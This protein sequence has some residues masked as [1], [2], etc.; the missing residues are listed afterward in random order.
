MPLTTVVALQ[1]DALVFALVVPSDWQDRVGDHKVIGA[2][3]AS[4][5][6]LQ[7][8]VQTAERGFV[9]VAA[10]PIDQAAAIPLVGF[11]DS[12][13][14]RLAA[15]M[16]LHLIDFD[17]ADRLWRGLG[18]VPVHV[19]EDPAAHRRRGHAQE[20]AL[21]TQGQ[22]IPV[23]RDRRPLRVPGTPASGARVN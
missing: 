13:F 11:P 19:P 12:E 5:P 3:Q 14:L 10:F 22:S 23:E 4:A 7:A 15:E 16:V 21:A 1:R 17:D 6:A 2:E 18:A 9:T 20:L 8:P